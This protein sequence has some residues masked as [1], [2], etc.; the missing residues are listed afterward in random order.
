MCEQRLREAIEYLRIHN[1]YK[2]STSDQPL[3]RHMT[4]P[5]L[6]A[7]YRSNL[8]DLLGGIADADPALASETWVR[9]AVD[10]M[11]DV[12]VDGRVPLVKNYGKKL[13]DPIP[14]ERV[15]EPSRFLT[16]EWLTVRRKL[17]GSM[18]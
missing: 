5:S 8:L 4:Q 12:T 9:E 6:V 14:L 10:D 13:M 2:K 11:D 1:L 16:Y 18:R 3:F 17:T 7:D 15:G